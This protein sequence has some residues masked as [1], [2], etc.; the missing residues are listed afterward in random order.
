MDANGGEAIGE[1]GGGLSDVDEEMNVVEAGGDEIQEEY[2]PEGGQGF[3]LKRR[4]REIRHYDRFDRHRG[5]KPE[6]RTNCKAMLS[7][8]LKNEQKWKVRK[9]VLEHN[10]NLAP[11]GM[12]HLIWSHRKITDATK[13][14]INEMHTYGIGTSKI[15]DY[16]A[17]SFG[18]SISF[19]TGPV[20]V[21][22][23]SGFKSPASTGPFFGVS[24]VT[25]GTAGNGIQSEFMR[26][27]K[28]ESGEK[29]SKQDLR[30]E[31]E[32]GSRGER[33]REQRRERGNSCS[34]TAVPLPPRNA[35]AA[36]EIHHRKFSGIDRKI[37]STCV[38]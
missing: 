11:A 15:L 34:S 23:D 32:L 29:E 24:K 35:A 2:L 10:H 16:M 6:T 27:R 5:N 18:I 19:P 30:R 14:Y 36:T 20:I 12:F 9:V 3:D 17:R 38:D 21:T 22:S 37:L 13:A 31:R 8:Y 1:C 28:R 4:L 26:W 25:K 33:A 7:I